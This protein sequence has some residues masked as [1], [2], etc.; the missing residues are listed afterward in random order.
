MPHP[1]FYFNK[2]GK[3][4]D[5]A[6]L[7]AENKSL[8]IKSYLEYL[9]YTNEVIKKIVNSILDNTKKPVVIILMGDHGFRT[10]QPKLYDFRNQNAI[11]IS[12]G[13][14]KGFY[15]GISNVNEFRVLFNNLFHA[16]LPLL[17]DSTSFL[18]DK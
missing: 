15:D 7:I 9:P 3:Q 11:Y 18:V 10:K 1:P 13:N 8:P 5:K 4:D 6:T 12:T 17:K 2:K 16:S 14:Y